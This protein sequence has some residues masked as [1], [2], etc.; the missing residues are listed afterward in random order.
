[1]FHLPE[2]ICDYD[3]TAARIIQNILPPVTVALCPTCFC[4]RSCTFCSNA[5]RNRS[6]RQKNAEYSSKIFAG[7]ADDLK[8]LGVMGVTL[9]GGGEPLAYNSADLR[10]FLTDA[11]A[12]YRVGIPCKVH[13]MHPPKPRLRPSMLVFSDHRRLNS[14]VFYI[15]NFYQHALTYSK[16]KF[17]IIL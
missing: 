16:R 1:M 6:N 9:A 13:S 10:S 11:Q 5:Q 2:R 3:L 15:F 17:A 8:N 14:A 4:M 7:I 12:Q